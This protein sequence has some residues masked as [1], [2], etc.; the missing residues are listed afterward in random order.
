M[1]IHPTA[2]VDPSATIAA[3]V[4][5]GAYSIIGAEVSIGEGC[6]IGPHV[7]INGPTCIGRENKIFQFAS[8]GDAPQD[9]KYAGEPTRLEIGDRNVIRE[10]CTINRGTV[11]DEGVT[12]IGCDNWIMAYV[13]VA[14]DCVVG[15]NIILANNVA[16]AGHVSVGD[17]AILGGFTLVHQFCA[18]GTHA[19][20]AMGSGIGKDVPPFLMVSGN[21][22]H[23]HGLNS[24]GLKRRGFSPEAMSA[25]RKAYKVLYRSGL[26]LKEAMPQLAALQAGQPEVGLFTEFLQRQTRGIVR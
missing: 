17:F 18:I 23:A 10:C 3:N 21:P 8:I 16:L 15:N 22:A 9:K 19:F 4:T 20:T 14:H 26:T 1:S 6:W 25:L 13:H 24:E 11:Q 2:I 7:V 12:R 5:I